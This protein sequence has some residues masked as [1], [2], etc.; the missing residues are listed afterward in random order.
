MSAM[1]SSDDLLF[2][3]GS[4]VTMYLTGWASGYVIQMFKRLME[5]I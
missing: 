1:V 4:L 5:M 3:V 2:V